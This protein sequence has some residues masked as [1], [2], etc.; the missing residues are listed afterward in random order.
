MGFRTKS[1]RISVSRTAGRIPLLVLALP[2]H[3]LMHWYDSYENFCFR[4]G[5]G[6]WGFVLVWFWVFLFVVW[7]F[8]LF[9]GFFLNQNLM[10]VFCHLFPPTSPPG[11]IQLMCSACS[12]R[13]RVVNLSSPSH[14]DT[15]PEDKLSCSSMPYQVLWWCCLASP[16]TFP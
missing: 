6:V 10:S 14:C 1:R 2:K 4:L 16:D 12:G 5:F 3:L 13:G 9:A 11:M 7:G 8:C 15:G